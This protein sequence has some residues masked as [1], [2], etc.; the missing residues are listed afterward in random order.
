MRKA[1]IDKPDRRFVFILHEWNRVTEFMSLLGNCFEDE[2]RSYGPDSWFRDDREKHRFGFSDNDERRILPDNIKIILTG[3]PSQDEYS[4]ETADFLADGALA[5][6]RLLGTEVEFT[7]GKHYSLSRDL[8]K[9]EE[10]AAEIGRLASDGGLVGDLGDKLRRNEFPCSIIVDNVLK[11]LGPSQEHLEEITK[12]MN[13][14]IVERIN[15]GKIV[16]EVRRYIRANPQLLVEMSDQLEAE[17]QDSPTL[18]EN[19][20]EKLHQFIDEENWSEAKALLRER[21]EDLWHDYQ[22][23]L[24]DSKTTLILAIEKCMISNEFEEV[25][26]ELIDGMKS[27][28]SEDISA[29]AN[30]KN[31]QPFTS[32]TRAIYGLHDSIGIAILGAQYK[33]PLKQVS[34]IYYRGCLEFLE[35]RPK[36]EQTVEREQI[37]NRLR[38]A[39]QTDQQMT[40][41]TPLVASED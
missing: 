17:S 21:N 3:N 37:C 23:P 18:S 4:G 35:G 29:I 34:S 16:A 5:R 30:L 31:N 36:E 40:D 12:K 27:K 1:A 39:L 20:W 28:Y 10:Q 26:R 33:F 19:L 14:L 8:V 7:D 24:A 22:A 32:L 13:E 15:P 38:G 6:N 41:A 9:E 25:A 11:R 2:L